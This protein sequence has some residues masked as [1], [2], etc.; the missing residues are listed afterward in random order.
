[1]F[2]LF[3]I[4]HVKKKKWNSQ[5]TLKDFIFFLHKFFFEKKILEKINYS[6]NNI[7][8]V[9]IAKLLRYPKGKNIY[10]KYV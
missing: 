5:T 3:W 10:N 2:I 7:I 9:K 6:E 4:F 8:S 1:M